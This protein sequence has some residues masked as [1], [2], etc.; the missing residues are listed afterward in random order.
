MPSTLRENICV[1]FQ[2]FRVINEKFAI[3][4]FTKIVEL[5]ELHNFADDINYGSSSQFYRNRKNKYIGKI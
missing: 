3:N 5:T 2:C 1:F 4:L